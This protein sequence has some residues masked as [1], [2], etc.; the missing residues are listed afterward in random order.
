[1]SLEAT[2]IMQQLAT[3]RA[4]ER[5]NI[6]AKVRR[7]R[8][9]YDATLADMFEEHQERFL[10]PTLLD[11]V[12]GGREVGARARSRFSPAMFVYRNEIR[13][14]VDKRAEAV[15]TTMT[16]RSTDAGLEDWA[17]G[18]LKQPVFGDDHNFWQQQEPWNKELEK[19]GNLILVLAPGANGEVNVRRMRT[20]DVDMIYNGEN[21][22]EVYGYEFSWDVHYID[23]KGERNTAHVVY[24]VG[25]NGY[26]KLVNNEVVQETKIALPFLP[27]VHVIA[28]P[29]DG[30]VLGKSV[31]EDLIEPQLLINA[32]LTDIRMANRLGPF[33]IF[34]GTVP[35]ESFLYTPG[36]YN[37][38]ETG[39]TI[40]RLDTNTD[41]GNL[42]EELASHRRHLYDKGRVNPR[43]DE[44]LRSLGNTPSGKALLVLNQDGIQ[45]LEGKVARLAAAWQ[46]MLAKAAVLAG[47]VSPERYKK[48][49]HSLFEVE[50]GSLDLEDPEIHVK[51]MQLGLG[52]HTAGALT[53]KR[54]LQLAQVKGVIPD[55]WDVDEILQEVEEES[56]KEQAGQYFSVG[57]QGNVTQ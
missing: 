31:I 48:E 16:V 3:R 29:I 30:F 57:E 36:A 47:K 21:I 34:Y 35:A 45:Y 1:V 38:V 9:F 8:K 17:R 13:D 15:P 46:E 43:T 28:E 42:R 26:T 20:E 39:E 11:V 2:E 18:F 32:C 49:G 40:S 44:Q 54:L 50:Y 52:L 12:S 41:T 19:T 10:R 56:T 23:E 53:K 24:R 4:S 37:P 14:I 55:S 33:P 6:R 27:I 22:E 5:F 25:R 7:W 51:E